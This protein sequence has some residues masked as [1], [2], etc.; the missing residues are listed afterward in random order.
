M[1]LN[2]ARKAGDPAA[3]AIQLEGLSLLEWQEGHLEESVRF[4]SAAEF[5]AAK[6]SIQDWGR[7]PEHA[8]RMADLE[9][10]IPKE[11]MQQLWQEG[12][13]LGRKQQKRA[14]SAGKD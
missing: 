7:D 13:L 3:V 2:Y 8:R 11:R 1:A 5:I 6:L 12:Q 10:R 14:Q 4:A 9:Q